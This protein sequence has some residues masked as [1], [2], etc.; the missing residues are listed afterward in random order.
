MS[1]CPKARR[2]S[3]FRRSERTKERTCEEQLQRALHLSSGGD[4]ISYGHGQ[5][6]HGRGEPPLK[7]AREKTL[8]RC[9]IGLVC[10]SSSCNMRVQYADLVIRGRCDTSNDIAA[11]SDKPLLMSFAEAP[12]MNESFQ[13][14]RINSESSAICMPRHH[15]AVDTTARRLGPS[16]WP[17]LAPRFSTLASACQC[18]SHK[19]PAARVMKEADDGQLRAAR[20]SALVTYYT[21]QFAMRNDNAHTR[22]AEGCASAPSRPLPNLTLM[23]CSSL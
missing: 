3:R 19:R 5:P 6:K 23:A 18:F 16:R 12:L 10:P 9:K 22:R 7:R 8:T 1:V 2:R 21:L 15:R 14:A 20:S 11:Q 17:P 13:S 4:L